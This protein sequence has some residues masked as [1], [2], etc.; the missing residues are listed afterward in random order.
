MS[1]E[2]L[3]TRFVTRTDC[4]AIQTLRDGSW[5]Y[6][7]VRR[8]LSDTVLAEHLAGTHTIGV[9]PSAQSTTKWLVI[10]I[11]S[12]DMHALHQVLGRAAAFPFLLEN[13]G[14]K[15]FHVWLF[16]AQPVPNKDARRLG[17]SLTTEHEVFPKQDQTTDKHPGNLIKLPLGVHQATGRR[18]LFL[19]PTTLTPLPDQW[20]ALGSIGLVSPDQI[21]QSRPSRICLARLPCIPTLRPCVAEALGHGVS[22]GM[23]NRT[24][25]VIAVELHRAGY[26][27]QE[28]YQQLSLWNERNL[29]PLPQRE[30]FLITR[31]VF[32]HPYRLS[33]AP[34]GVLRNVLLC[35]GRS[36]CSWFLETKGACHVLPQSREASRR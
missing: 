4:Y 6:Q 32:A 33:C 15:G 18:C 29:P 7:P 30:V 35:P 12:P 36:R 19:D 28:T 13:S 31:S 27:W 16:F 2:L 14:R 3:H 5:I 8:E 24:G 34:H 23:R 25:F 26:S 10:D 1:I 17:R 20:S 11:D 22:E 21:P 9:Y